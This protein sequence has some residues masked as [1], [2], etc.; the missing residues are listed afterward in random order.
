MLCV[1]LIL[2]GLTLQAQQIKVT[3]TVT[4]AGDGST[5]PGVSVQV[6]GTNQGTVTNVD[7]TYELNVAPDGVLVYRFIGMTTREITV[8][9]R[10][11]IDVALETAATALS[12]VVVMGYGTERAVGSVVGS[13]S[14]V[15]A[16]EI[17]S[18]PMANVWDAMQG[19]IAGV[20]VYTST[21]EP[22]ESSSV[23]LHGVGSLS[24]SSTPLY[25]LDGVP[26]AS[27]NVLSL[28]PNDIENVTFLKD[29]SAT[30]IYGSRAANG[31]MYITTKRGHRDQQ[32][33]VRLNSQ[34]GFSSLANTS[35]FESF[36][37]ADQL[38]S[39]WQE[40][41]FRSEDQIRELREQY[42]GDTRWHEYFY[43]QNTPTYQGDL[44]M[45]G[46]GGR[47][48]YYVSGAYFY[49]D[50]VAARSDY[51]RY[52]MR[53]NI[54]SHANDLLSFGTNLG[55]SY[56]N[57]QITPMFAG[58]NNSY[59]NYGLMELL[60]P[61]YSPYDEDGEKYD[62]IPGL[63]IV[64]PQYREK[65]EPAIGNNMQL[66]ISGYL[67]LNPAEGLTIRSQGGIDAYDYRETETI[68]PLHI[69]YSG[70]GSLR[71]Y[72]SRSNTMSITNTAE[73]KFNTI[74][75]NDFT[76]L[77][78][79]EYIQNDYNNFFSE[80]EGISDDRLILLGAGDPGTRGIGQEKSDYAY[81]SF[82]GRIDYARDRKY[83]ADFS[84][85]QDE[86]S[87][88][89]RENRSATFWSAGVMWD[90]AKESF[91]ENLD[92]MSSLRFK[93]SIG[94][95]GNSEIGNYRHL[96]TMGTFNPYQG[97]ASW[98]IAS[99][100]NPRL[101]WEEQTKTTI[102]ADFGLWDNRIKSTIDFYL[103]DTESMLMAVPQPY[104]SG[105]DE[106]MENVGSMRNSGVD[107]S[108][109]L[110]FIT[111]SDY[112]LTAYTNVNYN[113]NEITG[114]FHGHDHWFI[115]NTNIGYIVGKPVAFVAPIFAG[116]DPE[117]GKA[118]WY[119][120]GEDRSVM[121]REET[122]KTFVEA[123]L[124]QYTGKDRYAPWS[125]GFGL[126]SGWKGL[127]MQMDF[128][129]SSGHYMINNDR[130]FSE[131]P[132]V[133]Q[134]YNQSK[135]VVDYWKNPGDV[136]RFPAWGEQFTQFDT[137]LLE[138]ASFIRLKNITLSWELP[139]RWLA[140][141]GTLGGVRV[142]ASGRNLLTFTNYKGKDPEVDSN[143]AMARNPNSRQ[144]SF[145]VSLTM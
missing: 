123:D 108:L 90:A 91:M 16:A 116:I 60:V 142:F 70:N 135:D 132:T 31:V 59:L 35:Y 137:R 8:E 77:V 138:S 129:F 95:S 122:T 139:E 3:G 75:R 24:A 36:M 130:Y 65:Y 85:R 41:G 134:G 42:P 97:S 47:T 22:S 107:L 14:T 15:N 93:A 72:F 23:R 92:M 5:L 115:A 111:G 67:Q 58:T 45:Q 120:P 54:N 126:N 37:N 19:K 25:V 44:S 4:D 141:A 94:T 27:A 29:A 113:K 28:N 26:I 62:Y 76:F 136:T 48:T 110:N 61:F 84:L 112:F 66:N 86:S 106:I 63:N 18:R 13:I 145:G 81:S 118:M 133:F 103:R 10:S 99:P 49:Q 88:F 21:G 69:E 46:G 17:E 20:Q 109:S 74:L 127:T 12:E 6:K 39:F 100:G 98:L 105:F 56:D 79:Q 38:A 121:R 89:G 128:S 96:A 55:L 11:I 50:G 9:G 33:T 34:Y 52:S 73:Y 80:V 40:T 131:N 78:G 30:S 68:S 140:G 7:G 53:V 57:R 125:G 144:I 2:T 32:A 1:C 87:R 124:E 71:E 114:L 104:V 119:V 64:N 51:E 143:L 83:Y 82:F 117:D 102:G 43:Q 101:T